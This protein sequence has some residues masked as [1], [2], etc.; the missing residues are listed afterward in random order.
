MHTGGYIAYIT[1]AIDGEKVPEAPWVYHV[2]EGPGTSA[3]TLT[4]W[5]R[6]KTIARAGLT[7]FA[8]EKEAMEDALRR[9]REA[10]AKWI[11]TKDRFPEENSNRLKFTD[12]KRYYNGYY[13]R[14]RFYAETPP[15]AESGIPTTW[16]PEG[17]IAWR[18][19]DANELY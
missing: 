8:T 4:L 2:I 9:I 15:S 12:G 11:E 6:S 14:G 17:I 19:M 5:D 7:V 13:K 18:Q 10:K 1:R 16:Q 3:E